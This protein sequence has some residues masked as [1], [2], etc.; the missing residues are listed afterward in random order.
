MENFIQLSKKVRLS[1]LGLSVLVI[2]LDQLTKQLVRSSLNLYQVKSF[3]PFW[4][5]TLAF[6]E[7]AA[8]SFLANQSGWQKIFFALIAFIVSVG[9]IY[10]ILTKSYSLLAGIAFGFILG[11]ALGNLIDRVVAGKVTDFIDWYIGSHHWPAFNVADSFITVGVT[12]LI[13]DSIFFSKK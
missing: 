4:N 9:L 5:W 10:F 12:L 13:I 11:G 2:I 3:L 1:L 7:G 6:N 8:F